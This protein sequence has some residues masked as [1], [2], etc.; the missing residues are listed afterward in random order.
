MFQFDSD[1]SHFLLTLS[2]CFPGCIAASQR[3]DNVYVS[4]I[5]NGEVTTMLM[6]RGPLLPWRA[7]KLALSVRLRLSV[8]PAAT[9][10]SC[11]ARP[12]ASS[13]APGGPFST[14]PDSTAAGTSGLAPETQSPSGNGRFHGYSSRRSLR[15]SRGDELRFSALTEFLL[16]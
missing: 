12:A 15:T 3:N 1:A 16:L 14:R 4:G 8:Q 7:A 10:L 6:S 13:P 5:S 11:C 2:P 9:W